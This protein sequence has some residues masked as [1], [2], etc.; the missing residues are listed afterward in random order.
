MS[1]TASSGHDPSAGDTTSL[2]LQKRPR[3]A[4]L[5]EQLVRAGC[6]ESVLAE[7]IVVT[8]EMLAGYRGGRLPIPIDR[9]LCL[10]LYAIEHVPAARR[11]GF[12]L[13]AQVEAEIALARA[14]TEVHDAPPVSHRWP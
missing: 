9:Q 2:P 11:A 4:R 7:A 1:S 8:E 10:A 3:A 5:L 13:R 14:S 6:T 12:T